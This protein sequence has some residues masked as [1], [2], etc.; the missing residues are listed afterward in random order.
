[1]FQHQKI[2]MFTLFT[3]LMTGFIPSAVTALS[4]NQSPKCLPEL[5]LRETSRYNPSRREHKDRLPA[6][7]W[8]IH[9]VNSGG[10]KEIYTAIDSKKHVL[11]LHATAHR[12]GFEI[13]RVCER[14]FTYPIYGKIVESNFEGYRVRVENIF[15]MD[16]YLYKRGFYLYGTS[17]QQIDTYYQNKKEKEDRIFRKQH[18]KLAHILEVTS[19]VFSFLFSFVIFI[20]IPYFMFCGC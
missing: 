5:F 15:R 7:S 18:P 8:K 16:V 6:E 2:K 17:R 13:Y 12:I 14:D 3:I 19:F 10:A 20:V 11:M 1:M 4:G 9:M